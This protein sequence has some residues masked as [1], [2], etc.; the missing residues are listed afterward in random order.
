VYVTVMVTRE[1]YCR[2]TKQWTPF[3]VPSDARVNEMPPAVLW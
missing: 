3:P 1:Q 2:S